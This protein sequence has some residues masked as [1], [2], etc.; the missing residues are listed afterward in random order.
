VQSLG[1]A[2][3]VQQVVAEVV[4]CVHVYANEAVHYNQV[5]ALHLFL[6][7]ADEADFHLRPPV[8]R[9]DTKQGT[10]LRM[11]STCSTCRTQDHSLVYL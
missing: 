5:G 8:L 9:T 11:A 10:H 6:A 3:G 4:G 1:L 7:V 2:R